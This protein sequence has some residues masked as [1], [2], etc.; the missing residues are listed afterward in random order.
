MRKFVYVLLYVLIGNADNESK[1]VL[2]IRNQHDIVF[3]SIFSVRNCNTEDI[4]SSSCP[5][6]TK[7]VEHQ[8][9]SNNGHCQCQKGHV[10]NPKYTSNLDYCIN[11]NIKH[12]S[13]VP[14]EEELK[15]MAQPH[16]MVAGIV[17]PIVLVFIVIGLMMMAFKKLHILRHIRQSPFY[18]DVMLGDDP[19]LI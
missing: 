3:H 14:H 17:I 2:I 13:S 16:H 9:G 15:A 7:C 1:L 11:E 4:L 5:F 6:S 10:F 18:E 12:N 8:P 19:P